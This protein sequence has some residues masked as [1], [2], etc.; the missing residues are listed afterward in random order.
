MSIAKTAA[1][2][3]SIFQKFER[4][5]SVM[6]IMAQTIAT[7]ATPVLICYSEKTISLRVT[8]STTD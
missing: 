8:M 2:I 6:V 3:N 5:I 7:N 4:V 1:Q